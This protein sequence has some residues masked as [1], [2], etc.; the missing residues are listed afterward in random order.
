MIWVI[1][2]FYNRTKI[3]WAYMKYIKHNIYRCIIY[4]YIYIFLKLNLKSK[5]KLF[6]DG[7]KTLGYQNLLSVLYTSLK[8][9]IS[10]VVKKIKY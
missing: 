10:T 9:R 4:I 3:C 8:N 1:Q 5:Y 2:V 6:V 7:D